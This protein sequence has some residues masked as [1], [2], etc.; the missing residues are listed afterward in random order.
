MAKTITIKDKLGNEYTLEYTRRSVELLERKGFKLEE[1][2]KFPLT[3][4]PT[5]FE[6]AFLAHHKQIKKETVDEIFASLKN[7]DE[8]FGKLAEMYSEPIEA[9]VAEPEDDEGNATWEACW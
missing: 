4:L 5:L 2:G 3:M 1:I 9:Y 7:K 8:L 6:G